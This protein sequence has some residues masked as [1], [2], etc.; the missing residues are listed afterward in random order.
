M[1]NKKLVATTVS[2]RAAG[3]IRRM[4]GTTMRSQEEPKTCTEPENES[5]RETGGSTQGLRHIDG[6]VP[7]CMRNEDKDAGMNSKEIEK[8]REEKVE[9]DIDIVTLKV[10]YHC[11]RDGKMK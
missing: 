7:M 3:I 1:D 2:I 8:E 9:A 11:V 10:T 5:V 6:D 4:E